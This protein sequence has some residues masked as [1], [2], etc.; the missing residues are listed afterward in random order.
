DQDHEFE[1]DRPTA[2]SGMRIG[3][4]H[5]GK[6]VWIGAKATITR[7]VSI[8][9]NAVIGANAVVTKD[10]PENAVVCGV[11]AKITRFHG[12]DIGIPD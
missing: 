12:N 10:V 6:N 8:S 9:D 5:I 7:G 11:P 4:I 1:A 2:D 3:A